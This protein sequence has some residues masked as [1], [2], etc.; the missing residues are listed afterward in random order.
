MNFE[1][2]SDGKINTWLNPVVKHAYN[3]RG[4]AYLQKGEHSKAITDFTE[5]IQLD[6]TQPIFYEC[7]ARAHRAIGDEASAASDEKEAYELGS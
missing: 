3:S 7:R 5:A 1:M 2:Y 4:I 6:S